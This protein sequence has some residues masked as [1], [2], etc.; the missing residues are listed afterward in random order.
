MNLTRPLK[1]SLSTD[2]ENRMT[3]PRPLL[4]PAH[5]EATRTLRTLIGFAAAWGAALLPIGNV[6]AATTPSQAPLY[7][8]V[9]GAKPNLMFV[10]DNSGSMAYEYPEGYSMLSNCKDATCNYAWYRMRSSGVNAQYYNPSI[11]YLPRVEANGA[12][13]ENPLVFIDNQ[14]SR[15]FSYSLSEINYSLSNLNYVPAYK[16]Y[17]LAADVG[18]DANSVMSIAKTVL[19]PHMKRS[20]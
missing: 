2:R 10:L 20:I 15:T 13:Q 12:L 18:E 6:L 9:P 17:S 19:A 3:A 4:V 5:A 7:N 11:T 16:K 8:A 14:E 1:P